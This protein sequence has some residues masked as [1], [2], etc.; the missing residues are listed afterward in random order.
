MCVYM[1]VC[2]CV[3]ACVCVILTNGK[4]RSGGCSVAG[5]VSSNQLQSVSAGL[6]LTDVNMKVLWAYN[7]QSDRE[8][9]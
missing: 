6:E 9:R 3:C 4:L 5:S 7:T 1:C 8:K 2:V